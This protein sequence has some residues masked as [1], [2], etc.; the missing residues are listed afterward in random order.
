MS[1]DSKNCV[2]FQ[3]VKF[4]R[5]ILKNIDVIKLGSNLFL[6]WAICIR[7][8]QFAF[9]ASNSVVTMWHLWDTVKLKI[10]GKKSF[11]KEGKPQ[12]AM[13]TKLENTAEFESKQRNIDMRN[14]SYRKTACPPCWAWYITSPAEWGN[15]S[16]S[17]ESVS[18]N[19]K[20][21]TFQIDNS[22]R[23]LRT[24]AGIIWTVSKFFCVQKFF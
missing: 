1:S 13:T 6:M 21:E 3:V 9:D 22:Q 10:E 7:C 20:P 24:Q 19:C 4:E 16:W 8:E 23:I 14:D 5:T 2:S 17:R 15:D 11:K 12:S 18:F